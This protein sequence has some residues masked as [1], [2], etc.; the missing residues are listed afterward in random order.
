[1]IQESVGFEARF[2]ENLFPAEAKNFWFKNRNRL[3]QWALQHYFPDAQSFLEVGCGTGFVLAGLEQAF[4]K[5]SLAGSEIFDEGLLFAATR[6][7]RTSLYQ[8]DSRSIPFVD[9][10]DV[11]GAFDVLEHV[12]EDALVL[13][14]MHRATRPGGG[15]I[16]TVPQH[17][18]LWSSSDDYARHQRRYQRKELLEKVV[19]AGFRMVRITSFVS[20]LLPLMFAARRLRPGRAAYD[21]NAEFNI[22]LWQNTVFESILSTEA[23]AI[24]CGIDFPVGGSLLLVARR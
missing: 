17:R 22:P 1:M 2:F 13:N 6:L 14:E 19:T 15:I 5:L 23:F 8:M 24:R 12:S 10:F 4:P 11:I 7:T 18:W 9:E 16:L 21:P 20:L 3:I